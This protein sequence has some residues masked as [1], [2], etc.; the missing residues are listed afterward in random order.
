M[1]DQNVNLYPLNRELSSTINHG[2]NHQARHTNDEKTPSNTDKF[3]VDYKYK[4]DLKFNA[5]TT[6]ASSLKLELRQ[7]T[8]FKAITITSRSQKQRTITFLLSFQ[9]DLAIKVFQ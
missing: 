4:T 2:Q 5:G 3:G 1:T 6:L 9:S 7:L 8:Q